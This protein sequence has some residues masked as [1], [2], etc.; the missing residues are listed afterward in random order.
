MQRGDKHR[1]FV[2]KRAAPTLLQIA[3]DRITK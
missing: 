1:Q 3:A 2:L